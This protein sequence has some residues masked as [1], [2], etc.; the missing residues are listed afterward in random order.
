MWI[1]VK[2]VR[3]SSRCS[4][5]STENDMSGSRNGEEEKDSRVS[6]NDESVPRLQHAIVQD[7]RIGLVVDWPIQIIQ[8]QLGNGPRPLE[9]RAEPAHSKLKVVT[10]ER[11]VN[12]KA[13]VIRLYSML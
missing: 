9:H 13:N 11:T 8:P 10:D 3:L 4:Q 12:D 5:I 6:S 7:Q 1:K 2:L